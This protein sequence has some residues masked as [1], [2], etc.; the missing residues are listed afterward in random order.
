MEPCMETLAD[1]ATLTRLQPHQIVEYARRPY[2]VVRVNDCR[3]ALL[4]VTKTRP[5]PCVQRGQ[6]FMRNISASL[7]EKQILESV[8]RV[9]RGEPPVKDVTRRLGWEYLK[10]GERLQVCRK[11]MGRKPGEPLVKLAVIEVVSVR[12]ETLN[13]LT[14]YLFTG[15]LTLMT[16]GA[17][18]REEAQAEVV[19]EG[20]LFTKDFNLFVPSEDKKVATPMQ[21]VQFFCATH[22]HC[23]PA[24]PITRIE[25]KYLV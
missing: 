12:R 18:T 16:T 24:T 25:F 8:E 10:V 7:T 5:S 23:T 15:V 19:R 20:F 4:P 21:F 14:E 3:A 17:Y 22:K 1:R 2:R 13:H 11:C 9:K 6:K